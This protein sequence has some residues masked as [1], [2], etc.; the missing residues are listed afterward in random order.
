MKRLTALLLALA[1]AACLL[2][3]CGGTPEV[4]AQDNGSGSGSE[5]A[6]PEA[7]PV[8]PIQLPDQE[9]ETIQ[10]NAFRVEKFSGGKGLETFAE[11]LEAVEPIP[12]REVQIGGI[13]AIVTL[14]Y[15]D[16][17]KECFDF[18]QSEVDDSVWYVETEDGRLYQ[19]AEFITEYVP[20]I[21]SQ[22]WR[23]M[24]GS[25]ILPVVNV[26]VADPDA[27]R[28]RIRMELE[29]Q[30][31]EVSCNTTDLRAAFA[32]K[33]QELLTSCDEEKA[34]QLARDE[35]AW[36]MTQYQYAVEHGY[37]LTEEELDDRIEEY[38]AAWI[39]SPDF[40]EVESYY[41]EQGTT[42]AASRGAKREY[43][44]INFVRHNLYAGIYEDF[45]RGNNQ[46]GDQVCEDVGEYWTC[47][48]LDVLYPEM[49]DYSGKMLTPLLDEAEAFYR[50]HFSQAES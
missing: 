31:L 16:G 19:N 44:R 50:E 20:G 49:E 3:G 15:A 45:C 28:A 32:L 37:G 34:I 25:G 4:S 2:T 14:T 30:A 23:Q 35:L 22:V 41:A 5:A 43:D 8:P 29:L 6:E 42:F 33:V 47:F 18:I 24:T 27:V 7:E 9:L 26:E 1:F 46:I 38:N 12:A 17:T 39:K 48:L 21:S 36:E 13:G 11:D 10:I 40:D